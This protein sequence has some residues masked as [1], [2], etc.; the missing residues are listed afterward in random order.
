MNLCQEI[1]PRDIDKKY[2]LVLG[3]RLL[4]DQF[5][6]ELPYINECVDSYNGA[7]CRWVK[8]FDIVG[9]FSLRKM[10]CDQFKTALKGKMIPAKNSYFTRPVPIL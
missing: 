3:T 8:V 5:V 1:L 10:P 7:I 6:K 9:K 4:L 2:E